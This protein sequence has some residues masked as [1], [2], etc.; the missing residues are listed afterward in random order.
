[1]TREDRITITTEQG[2][3]RLLCSDP[4]DMRAIWR[5]AALDLGATE[6]EAMS[7]VLHF[8]GWIWCLVVFASPRHGDGYEI[9]TREIWRDESGHR[10]A[11]TATVALCDAVWGK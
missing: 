11:A 7:C 9:R 8:D 2:T 5:R 10:N 6:K 3:R 1:M 4:D